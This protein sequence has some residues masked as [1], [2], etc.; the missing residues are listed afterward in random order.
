[1]FTRNDGASYTKGLQKSLIFV[2]SAAICWLSLWILE[3]R[4]WVDAVFFASRHSKDR[5]SV[6]ANARWV[7]VSDHRRITFS[8]F[9]KAT[10][11]F[12]TVNCLL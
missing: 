6:T 5:S 2:I 3:G 4:H 9:L 11:P 10:I 12:I 1:M 8:E 7:I